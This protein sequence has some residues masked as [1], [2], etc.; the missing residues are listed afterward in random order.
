M[1]KVLI[2]LFITTSLA[3]FSAQQITFCPPGAEW[4]YLFTEF[5]PGFGFVNETI[6]Y[7]GNV[8]EGNDTLKLLT[9]K[10]FFTR[11]NVAPTFTTLIKQKG[12]TIFMRNARTNNQWQILYNFAALPNQSWTNTFNVGVGNPITYTTQVTSI[13]TK[14]IANKTVKEYTVNYSNSYG[15]AYDHSGTVTEHYGSRVFLFNYI[16]R[17]VT[18]GDSYLDFLCYYDS[19]INTIQF[20]DK[21]C[22]FSNLTDIENVN[23]FPKLNLYPNPVKDILTLETN[24][25]DDQISEVTI[26]NTF[27]QT[28]YCSDRPILQNSISLDFLSKGLYFLNIRI[29]SNQYTYKLLKE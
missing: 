28:V 1:K 29:N 21:P 17:A 2:L 20:T 10:K 7:T 19:T 12:D 16:S 3:R 5:F 11:I 22:D 14:Q 6:K 24:A 25:Y 4:H 13:G 8:V 27:G 23:P 26:T 9:H 18:D 15:S